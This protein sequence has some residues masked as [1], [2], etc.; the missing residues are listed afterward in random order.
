ML[1]TL[2]SK[3]LSSKTSSPKSSFKKLN[4]KKLKSIGKLTLKNKQH[5]KDKL[6][7]IKQYCDY[8]KKD[9][10]GKINKQLYKSCKINQYCRK[11]KCK[12]IDSKFRKAKR[13]IQVE[14]EVK[15]N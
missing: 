6:K 13:K 9:I 8:Y 10:T 5:N 2:S 12:K 14:V 4:S 11:Y 15:W 1:T 7:T 3:T